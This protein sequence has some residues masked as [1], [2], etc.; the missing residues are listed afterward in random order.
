MDSANLVSHTHKRK[1]E[2]TTPAA[3]ILLNVLRFPFTGTSQQ[4]HHRLVRC[5]YVS[6]A[7]F[8][9]LPARNYTRAPPNKATPI[10]FRYSLPRSFPGTFSFRQG[11]LAAS[12]RFRR[13]QD[14]L[15]SAREIGNKKSC[16][17]LPFK[18]TLFT[19]RRMQRS[20]V[21]Q[22]SCQLC[23]TPKTLARHSG[24]FT[25]FFYSS[26]L[27]DMLPLFGVFREKP[28]IAASLI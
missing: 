20:A 4:L 26:F 27:V 12:I 21:R 25:V 28:F 5:K 6:E 1:Y 19:C 22:C 7:S 2:Q 24:T 8:G 13:R 23:V 16:V 9:P 11:V 3:L 18:P 10:V 14:A 17:P 15:A